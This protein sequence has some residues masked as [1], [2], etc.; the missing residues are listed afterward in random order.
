MFL[1]TKDLLNAQLNGFHRVY[2]TPGRYKA[3]GE[4]NYQNVNVYCFTRTDLSF[5]RKSWHRVTGFTLSAFILP[6]L[7]NLFHARDRLLRGLSG[8]DIKMIYIPISPQ[9]E[10]KA[11]LKQKLSTAEVRWKQEKETEVAKIQS[12]LDQALR[13]IGEMEATVGQMASALEAE[14]AK[15]KAIQAK[16]AEIEAALHTSEGKCEL[17]RGKLVEQALARQGD[18]NR[19]T[20]LEMEERRLKAECAELTQKLEAAKRAAISEADTQAIKQLHQKTVKELETIRNQLANQS[21]ENA[22]LKKQVQNR[23]ERVQGQEKEITALKK[24]NEELGEKVRNKSE[25]NRSLNEELVKL[26]EE[27][28]SKTVAIKSSEAEANSVQAR[29]R[30]IEARANAAEDRA[31]SSESSKKKIEEDAVK[32]AA[33]AAEALKVAEAEKARQVEELRKQ[34]QDRKRLE[35]AQRRLEEQQRK[36]EQQAAERAEQLKKQ[37]EEQARLAEEKKRIEE[38]MLKADQE[39]RK[40]AAIIQ[41]KDAQ[42]S[43]HQEVVSFFL[44]RD[45]VQAR[46][47]IEKFDVQIKSQKARLAEL[48]KG[49]GREEEKADGPLDQTVFYDFAKVEKCKVTPEMVSNYFRTRK[50]TLNTIDDVKKVLARVQRN[51]DHGNRLIEHCI[52]QQKEKGAQSAFLLDSK[53]D[54]NASIY[55]HIPAELPLDHATLRKLQGE[56][57]PIY[58]EVMKAVTARLAELEAKQKMEMDAGSILNHLR[59]G[60]LRQR[61]ATFQSE[62]DDDEPTVDDF[63]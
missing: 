7:F 19:I 28:K 30:Q 5:C 38:E 61:S 22:A 49:K 45:N 44:Q 17:A 29:I 33:K 31:K 36:A 58:E 25:E 6:F 57:L 26:R 39:A 32:A 21:E 20:Q 54:V 42:L 2:K 16:L 63:D 35:D 55:C 13:T 9:Q 37:K 8:K 15:F 51:L 3:K 47:D 41:E 52:K 18:A 12:K 62:D 56:L 10:T 24:T 50:L 60:L 27:L 46:R 59:G 43:K 34:A 40:Q 11:Q 48:L 53:V 1:P 14:S 23:H 4:K